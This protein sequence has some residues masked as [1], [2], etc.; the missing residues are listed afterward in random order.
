MTFAPLSSWPAFLFC[1]PGM[2]CIPEFLRSVQWE[3]EGGRSRGTKV[4]QE[5][6][7]G[8]HALEVV[9]AHIFISRI[10]VHAFDTSRRGL[11]TGIEVLGASFSADNQYC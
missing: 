4:I 11:L 7:R 2:P 5:A 10:A 3:L 6:P 9:L 1:S 8:K